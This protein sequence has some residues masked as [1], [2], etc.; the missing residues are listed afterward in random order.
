M[1]SS[2]P[3]YIQYII[4]DIYTIGIISFYVNLAS[5]FVFIFREMNTK[6]SVTQNVCG[7]FHKLSLKLVVVGARFLIWME[8]YQH[9]LHITQHVI[10]LQKLIYI[11]IYKNHLSQISHKGCLQF[12]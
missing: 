1:P 2:F 10:K 5:S 4:H 3:K 9:I 6:K 12:E 8:M 7:M 11:Y